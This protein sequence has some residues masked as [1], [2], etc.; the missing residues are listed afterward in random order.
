LESDGRGLGKICSH[1]GIPIPNRHRAGGD[2]DA[3][4]L[5]FEKI[6]Q[7][8]GIEHIRTMLKSTSRE[9][10]LP[11]NLPAGQLENLP[12]S[13]GVYYFHDQKGKVIYVGKAK[14]LRRRVSSHFSNNKPGR[15]KQEFL[16]NIH[17]I[18]HEPTGTELM[19][20]L[21][22]CVEIRRLWPAYNR[23]LKRFQ[24]TYGLYVF[25]DRSG[26]TRLVL[27]KK[28]KQLTPIYTFSLLW[29]GQKI[30]WKLIRQFE[31]CPR[32]CFIEKGEGPCEGVKEHFCHGA[33]EHKESAETYNL[34]VQEAID[35]LVKSLPSF[36][37]VDEGR[38]PEEKSC[39]L[40]EQ[41]R[42]YGMGYLP[43][44]QSWGDPGNPIDTGE[45]K[46]FLT[47]YPENDYMRGLVYQHVEQWPTK[48]INLPL[49][50]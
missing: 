5:L 42:L 31:L 43:A 32:L 40:V 20:F 34:R 48:R 16:R 9:Q 41:G 25:E 2:A 26:Y 3:T 7:T 13:P 36:T 39:I 38:H 47:P 4:V 17:S 18:S 15:Q 24:Q 19:A 23:S 29:E 8:G 22:E 27:E 45:L 46:A 49:P 12:E 37:L 35:G 14:N 33:C 44:D 28:K 10:Y 11:S 6:L 1:L 30:L 21:L 50:A